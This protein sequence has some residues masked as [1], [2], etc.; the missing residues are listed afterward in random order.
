MSSAINTN[1]I[2]LCSIEINLQFFSFRFYDSTWFH[3]SVLDSMI[4][5]GFIHVLQGLLVDYDSFRTAIRV[6]KY[7][8]SLEKIHGLLLSEELVVKGKQI[9]INENIAQS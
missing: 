3:D 5:H 1:V 7:E 2:K 6:R 4:Q 9:K 8:V